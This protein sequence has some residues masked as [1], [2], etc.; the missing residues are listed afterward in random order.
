MIETAMLKVFT[1]ERL[2]ECDQRRVPD[3][4]RLGLLH[5]SSAGANAA[6]RAHQ[7][8]RRRQQRSAD[9]VHRAGRD[10]RT[11]HGVQGNLRHDVETV[12]RGG[13]SK[14]WSAGMNRLGATIRVPDVPVQSEQLRSH[15]WQL[16]AFDLAFQFRGQPRIDHV[17]R[18]DSRHAACSGT[19]RECGDGSFRVDLCSQPPGQRNSIRSSKRR[20]GGAGS[21][22][23]RSVFAAIISPDSR[24]PWRTDGQRRQSGVRRSKI[25][26]EQAAKLICLR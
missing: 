6:R 5:R 8:D 1:T 25:Q 3:S 9:V 18:T 11:G 4:R 10:A 20:C 23:C 17:S 13:S 7:P 22:C 24:F 19:N 12:A 26:P 15:A 16:G 21:R 2:W 14:A